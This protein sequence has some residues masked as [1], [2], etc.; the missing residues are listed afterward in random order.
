MMALVPDPD[1]VTTSGVARIEDDPSVRTAIA[2]QV[3]NSRR[4]AMWSGA[5]LVLLAL[6]LIGTQEFRQEHLVGRVLDIFVLD[7]GKVKRWT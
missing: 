4:I 2:R 6:L 7:R 3:R 5:V 1:P